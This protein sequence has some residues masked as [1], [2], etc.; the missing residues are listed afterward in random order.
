M[1]QIGEQIAPLA[2]QM[3]LIATGTQATL[4]NDLLNCYYDC[5]KKGY[6]TA[7]DIQNFADMYAAYRALKGNSFIEQIAKIFTHI[8]TETDYK[9]GE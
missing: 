2:N 8:P 9:K 7:E 4:R 5:K 6:R 1:K 3:N